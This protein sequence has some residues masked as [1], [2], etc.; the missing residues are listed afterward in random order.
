MIYTFSWDTAGQEQYRCVSKAYFRG[1]TGN[2]LVTIPDNLGVIVAF[3]LRDPLTFQHTKEWLEEVS[4]EN[5]SEF[6]VFLVGLKSDTFVSPI[7]FKW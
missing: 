4:K 6:V 5:K 1:A 2:N 3:D 7:P